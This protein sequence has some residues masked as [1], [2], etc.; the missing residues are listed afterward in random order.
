LT[1]GP[2]HTVN[3]V[4]LRVLVAAP[5]DQGLSLALAA[6][7]Q[8]FE[9]ECTHV[10]SADAL[11]GA[12]Q[13]EEWDLVL[14]SP[15][16]GDCGCRGILAALREMGSDVLVVA[17]TGQDDEKRD[18]ELIR[19]G[20]H[21]ALGPSALGRLVPL[22]ARELEEARSRRLRELRALL[23][24]SPDPMLIA[25][26]DGRIRHVNRLLEAL[27]GYAEAELA[28]QPV[29]L[30][31]PE[32]LRE[33]H[34]AER[35]RYVVSPQPRPMGAG[36]ELSARGK[37]GSNI[38]VEISLG[39]VQLGGERLVCCGLRDLR[40]RRSAERLL[41]SILEG[42]AAETGEA[43]LRALVKNLAQ[44]LDVRYAFVSELPRDGGEQA[45]ILAFWQG[46][47][48]GPSFDYATRGT[49]CQFAAEAFEFIVEDRVR[50]RFPGDLRLAGLGAE[51]FF[52]LRISDPGGAAA[53]VLAIVDVKP[54]ADVATARTV[55]RIFAASAGAE[56]ERMRMTATLRENV[57]TR[58]TLM[59]N[60]PG[61][62]YRCKNDPQWTVEFASHGCQQLTGYAPEDFIGNRSLCYADIIHPDDRDR[63]WRDV[64]AA[65]GE[66]QAFD[67]HYRIRTR[68]GATKWVWERG[69]GVFSQ[70]GELR[71]L[72]GYVTDV[73]VQAKAE[74]ALRETAA[75]MRLIAENVPAMI[76]YTDA[77]FRFRYANRQFAE[78]HAGKN[79]VAEGRTMAEF[80]GAAAFAAVRPGV[81]RALAGETVRYDVTRRRHDGALRH[82]DVTLVPHR[83]DGRQVLGVYTF[84]LDVTESRRAEEDL[85]DR[86][87]Q[88]RLLAENLPAMICYVGSDYRYRFANHSYIRFYAGG[89]G[90]LEGK[91]L[92]EVLEEQVLSAVRSNV[93]RALA[94]ETVNYQAQ[95]HDRSDGRLRDV[96]VS[97]VPHLDA[98]GRA[99]GVYVLI[100]DVTERQ[101]AEA[102]LRLRN[103]AIESSVNAIMITEPDGIGERQRIVY[104]NP[105]FEHTTGYAAAEVMGR[106]PGFLHRDDRDQP[107]VAALR[108]AAREGR[109]ATALVRNYR[110]DGTP[111]W[112]ELRVAPVRDDAGRVTHFVGVASDVSDRMRYQEEIERHANYDSLTGLPN[113]NLL[114]DRLAQ[115]LVKSERSKRPVGVL[116]VD[117]D[118]LKRINDSLGHAMGDQVIAAVGERL[119]GA[120]RT[121]DTVA[122]VGG[123]EFVIVLADLQREDDAALV[124]SKAL[125]FIG[126]PLKIGAHEFVLT[127]SAGLAIYP[128]DGG[129]A[130]T[131]LRYA[132]TALYR[133][134]E[135]GRDCFRFYA[136]EMNERVVG[137]VNLER[138]LRRAL[139]A[140]EFRLQYQP[141]VRLPSGESVGAEALIRWRR[142]DGSVI[143]PAQFIPVAEQ[144]GLIVQ[145]G[146][147][148]LETAARQAAEWN[149]GGR[150]PL[151]VS[152]NLSMRQ[153]RDRDLASAVRAAL[154]G[155]GLDPS[156]LKLEITETALMHDVEA[157]QR[158][159][160]ALKHLGVQLSIDDFGTGYSSL[161]YL[162][163]FPLDTLKID[164]S[165]V[166][167][168]PQDQDDAAIS[169]AVIDLG[170]RLELQVLAEGVETREQAAFLAA[171][172][173]HLAQGYL[174]GRPVDPAE[175][176]LPAARRIAAR[177]KRAAA[178]RRR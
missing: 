19:A 83:E 149:R 158:S 67:L 38:P 37:D 134:K 163:R 8:E 102:Q 167:G 43:F 169:R 31:V 172:G 104:V 108:A 6:L 58:D 23:Q 136:A 1:A 47:E 115:A 137:F 18:S 140:N 82:V 165:F 142:G 141:I 17:L 122:R 3:R 173:C 11:R 162:K 77:G 74:Q 39:P 93:E 105:A 13:A 72:E 118:H 59:H 28:G 178:R 120:V 164:R 20:A 14:C 66:R 161:A 68:D 133:A 34:V 123:D 106:S 65:I 130:A 49:P 95:R 94:G 84:A 112:N 132:D 9:V 168:L 53:G 56:L 103:R 69:S 75:R 175:F 146:R 177:R 98:S 81:E 151:Y 36:V 10:A 41:R 144:S 153:F 148:V 170:S 24:S 78:F 29:E 96:E 110:K 97:L 90:S 117:L 42:T 88:L 26:T 25:D 135:E 40:E 60:L 92:D 15:A 124:A 139:E 62:V 63:V 16:P 155:A 113:R 54:L 64:Q 107:G 109:E 159:L 57:R 150:V 147:W 45:R 52:G 111:F 99:L 116:Y 138:D 145:I 125:N 100:L 46:D 114:N 30:L 12:L 101:R 33:R 156:L 50:V 2:P 176:R 166:R 61:M 7:E 73:T 85:R 129:D 70:A 5:R 76:A 171:H 160:A 143:S 4:R 44:A 157:T 21:A 51:S 87:A 152:V 48:F 91:A 80:L 121:G 126:T 35:R 128:K 86:E 79:A 32:P 131:L 55:M 119:A 154:E 27:L 22:V 174:F 71:A 89:S 127:A